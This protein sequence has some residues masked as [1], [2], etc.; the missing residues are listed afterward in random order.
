MTALRFL[1]SLAAVGVIAGCSPAPG[2]PELD[3]IFAVMCADDDPEEPPHPC[4]TGFAMGGQVVTANHCVPGDRAQLVSRRQWLETSNESEIGTVV[5]RDEARDIAWL[6]APVEAQLTRGA[7]ISEGSSVSA[8]TLSGSKPG[9]ADAPAGAFWLTD[10]D[11]L[12]GDSGAAVVDAS[13][14]AVGVLSRC[15][16]ADGKQCDPHSGIFAELP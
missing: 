4:C 16:T 8:L 14:A 11:T 7:P 3:P 10:M 6:S 9:I 15:L 5:A 1:M 12:L 2:Q 13:G